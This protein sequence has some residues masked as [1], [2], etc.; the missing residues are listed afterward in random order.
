MLPLIY[1]TPQRLTGFTVYTLHM[2]LKAIL[3]MVT[4]YGVKNVVN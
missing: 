1:I 3:I 4:C 2:L